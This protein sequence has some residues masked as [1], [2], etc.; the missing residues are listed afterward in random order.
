MFSNLFGSYLIQKGIISTEQYAGIKAEQAKTRVKLGLIAVA[1][2][3]M[4]QEQADEVNEKQLVMDCRFGDIAVELGY[5]E[6]N[7][8]KNLL[9]HQGNPYIQFTQAATDLGFL[10]LEQ[11]DEAL[12]DFQKEKGFS[13][14]DMDA[15]KSGDIDRIIPLYLPEEL[16]W[17][18]AE[19]IAVLLRTMTRLVSGDV[20]ICDAYLTNEVKVNE[21]AL[22][23]INGD[24]IAGTAITG[25]EEGILAI[26][27]GFAKDLFGTV[28]P[29]ALDSVGEF[30]NI[31][32]GLFA[33]ALSLDMVEVSLTPP[34]LSENGGVMT[35]DQLCVIPIK[36]NGYDAD[37][38][39][40]VDANITVK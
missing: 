6:R 36:I 13:S 37:V 15:I 32:D 24:L 28:G 26:A 17:N 14:M 38:I 30:I 9:S 2:K 11:I 35:A 21:Y 1:E 23:G 10:T 18:T 27:Q 8:V 29:E 19:L 3:L 4:T 34:A 12:L 22:Q 5:L 39:V 20:L 40:S 33:T 16:P 7:Q 25:S 31:V